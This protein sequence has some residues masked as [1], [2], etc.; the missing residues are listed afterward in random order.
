[1][2]AIKSRKTNIIVLLFS[3]GFLF[4][5]SCAFGQQK[6]SLLRDTSLNYGKN[7]VTTLFPSYTIFFESKYS[8][9]DT[10]FVG[11]KA[12][13]INPRVVSPNLYTFVPKTYLIN[14]KFLLIGFEDGTAEKFPVVYIDKSEGYVEYDFTVTAYASLKHKKVSYIGFDSFSKFN[15]KECVT[16]FMDFLK[17][18]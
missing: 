18:L 10:M 9:S 6:M 13:S 15:S 5:A 16:Y 17:L 3:V 11:I 4:L 14:H 1:M 7:K 12:D 8:P 2:E